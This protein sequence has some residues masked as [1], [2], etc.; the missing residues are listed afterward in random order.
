MTAINKSNNLKHPIVISMYMKRINQTCGAAGQTTSL[1]C[2]STCV[3]HVTDWENRQDRN[4]SNVQMNCAVMAP[5][6][7]NLL[8]LIESFRNVDLVWQDENYFDSLLRKMSKVCE[9]LHED[10]SK[11]CLRVFHE[12]TYARQRCCQDRSAG[13]GILNIALKTKAQPVA[14]RAFHV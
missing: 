10:G 11:L 13:L 3:T 5:P 8:Q 12:P 7:G 4:N 1:T 6:G 9:N 2:S 14:G